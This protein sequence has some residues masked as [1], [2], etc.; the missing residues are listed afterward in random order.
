M[1]HECAERAQ[2]EGPA[3]IVTYGNT[4]RKRRPLDKEVLVFGRGA[5]CDVPLI[6]PQVASVHC[7]LVRLRDGW[8]LRDSSGHLGTRVNGQAVHDAWLCDGDHLQIGPFTFRLALPQA[9]ADT[10]PADI[11]G[12]A[13]GGERDRLQ[14][15]RRNLVRLARAYRERLLRLMARQPRPAAGE[16]S[17]LLAERDDLE[18]QWRRLEEAQQE[19]DNR[20]QALSREEGA[21]KERARK[22]EQDLLQRQQ[23]AE[24]LIEQAWADFRKR[25]AE[26][27]PAPVPARAAPA[28]P[29]APVAAVASDNGEA[30]RQLERRR[31]ELD[32]YAAHLRRWEQALHSTPD[33][34][35]PPDDV[36][37]T[38]LEEDLAKTQT[39]LRE[40]DDQVQ[41]LRKE[42]ANQAERSMS[43]HQV[44]VEQVGALQ[45]RLKDREGEIE[46]LSVLLDEQRVPEHLEHS[47]G[48]E[49]ELAQFRQ[50]L[51]QRRQ[52]LE[53]DALQVRT[54][55]TEILELARETELEL[56]R[57]RATLSRERAQLNRMREELRI[58]EDRLRRKTNLPGNQKLKDLMQEA[59]TN[60]REE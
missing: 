17:E 54:R 38:A 55:Q 44:V 41:L 11:E 43:R 19:V 27:P 52:Q 8:H 32:H 18:A 51:E 1:R 7:V 57:E 59:Q 39:I 35:A 15:S 46:R 3:L 16:N 50:E 33:A 56:S 20:R 22:L 40:R 60:G 23:E 6:S 21:L 14:A 34:G 36:V 53:Q 13:A 5:G 37:L 45:Q 29:A 26:A 4:T 12:A 30:G 49:R 9:A 10:A 24:K 31:A 42:L 28:A 58:E 48:Y 2:A 47:G 25:C